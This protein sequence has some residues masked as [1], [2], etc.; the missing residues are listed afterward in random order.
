MIKVK[1]SHT[2][3]K[4]FFSV[5][6]LF[7]WAL[8]LYLAFFLFLFVFFLSFS[9]CWV[10]Y[11]DTLTAHTHTHTHTHTLGSICFVRQCQISP[12]LSIFLLLFFS[13]FLCKLHISLSDLPILLRS[14]MHPWPLTSL[15]HGPCGFDLWSRSR[16][17]LPPSFCPSFSL[18]TTARSLS[19]T[20]THFTAWKC[21]SECVFVCLWVGR[22]FFLERIWYAII[23]IYEVSPD[24]PLWWCKRVTHAWQ[25][26]ET[27]V[28]LCVCV[29]VYEHVLKV[30]CGF[31]A[32]SGT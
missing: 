25:N 20:H 30:G 15:Y 12:P 18:W 9:H 8:L 4:L 2:F 13:L 19:L 28:V 11:L 22:D 14:F 3:V 31:C 16:S 17:Q 1:N 10:Q 21:V 6:C 5:H 24:I 27:Q 23:G 29:C 26:I 7:T 32:T